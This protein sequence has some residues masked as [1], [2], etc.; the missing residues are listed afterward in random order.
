MPWY[1][2]VGVRAAH[3]D[4]DGQVHEASG[5]GPS[6]RVGMLLQPP[7]QAP[8]WHAFWRSIERRETAVR[9]E[10][11]RQN[12][13]AWAHSPTTTLVLVLANVLVHLVGG[14]IAASRD[15][16][17]LVALG[18]LE[19]QRV[20]AGEVWRLLSCTFVHTDLVSLSGVTSLLLMVGFALEPVIG[21]ARFLLLFVAMALGSSVMSLFA[22]EALFYSGGFGA[23]SGLAVVLLGLAWIDGAQL[24]GAMRSHLRKSS[25]QVLAI[26][27]LNT[28]VGLP[29]LVCG[30]LVGLAFELAGLA[31]SVLRRPATAPTAA[32]ATG[33]SALL[34]RGAAWTGRLVVASV[35]L[36]LAFGRA[37]ELDDA[38]SFAR[39]PLGAT[40]WSAELPTGLEASAG[41][42][43]E[44][45]VFGGM[46][47]DPAQVVA[48]V[49]P[50]ASF[51][52]FEAPGGDG[53]AEEVA[54]GT[55]FDGVGLQEPFTRSEVE[56]RTVLEGH[57][58]NGN[59][60]HMVRAVV[61][62]DSAVVRVEVRSGAEGM[63]T[64]RQVARHVAVTAQ[65]D[66]GQGR[67]A[68]SP[69][70]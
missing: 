31:A 33:E 2:A 51:A 62:A 53:V 10:E 22:F 37:W 18:A 42:I 38:P 1:T 9:L 24:P 8:D 17:F 58:A 69:V 48:Q 50:R 41:P 13:G 30:G 63:K 4:D 67:E 6:R 70:L 49:I 57:Y 27:A 36:A 65:P 34:R 44:E 11:E 3:V 23:V 32:W 47:G 55:L 46:V 61:I 52:G 28:L 59:G 29:G 66:G 39:A 16:P 25:V 40:G 45:V 64:W 68:W 14:G 7:D 12:A 56:G 20:H 35:V 26:L 5:E 43:P 15:L 60:V 19:P 21:S 54:I